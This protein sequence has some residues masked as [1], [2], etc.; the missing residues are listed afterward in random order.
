LFTVKYSGESRI[1]WAFTHV[2]SGVLSA[3]AL[4]DQLPVLGAVERRIGGVLDRDAS[5][6]SDYRCVD[7][8]NGFG[9]GFDPADLL[10]QK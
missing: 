10:G 8:L 4:D 9:I 1:E 5:V 3:D 6:V 7:G 2:G